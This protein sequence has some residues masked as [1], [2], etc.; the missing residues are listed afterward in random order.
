MRSPRAVRGALVLLA[1]SAAAIGVPALLLPRTFYD[2][3]P[4]AR[5]WIDLLPPYNEHLV[6]DVGGLYVAF[7]LLFAWGA[8]TLSRELV[9]P[10]AA[11][12]TLAAVAHLVFHATHLGGF[13]AGDAA[14]Q[15]VSL[16]LV[17]LLPAVVVWAS[18]RAAPGSRSG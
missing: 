16:A 8:V 9:V 3:F 17:A 2:H 10:V 5:H 4:F 11:A 12:W 1:L 18:T 6:T 14:A 13:S 7:A 15:L